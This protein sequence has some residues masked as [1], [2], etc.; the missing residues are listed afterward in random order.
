MNM[1]CAITLRFSVY[2]LKSKQSIIASGSC[3]SQTPYF[4]YPLATRL[5]PSQK[6]LYSSPNK[7]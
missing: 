6:I 2:S 4:R 3:V 7:Y 5:N 1:K